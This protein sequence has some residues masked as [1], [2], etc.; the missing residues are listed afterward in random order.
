MP[1][2]AQ[3][4]ENTRNRAWAGGVEKN[5][6]INID[7]I[8]PVS[9]PQPVQPPDIVSI[10][11]AIG[12]SGEISDIVDISAAAILA[13]RLHEIPEV[14]TDLVA[15]VKEEIAAGTYETEERLDVTVERLMEELLP[16]L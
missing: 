16:E 12:P 5:L 7:G 10:G 14:R 11:P 4:D 2:A 8:H 13:A 1:K 3:P 6:M 9:A 15:R